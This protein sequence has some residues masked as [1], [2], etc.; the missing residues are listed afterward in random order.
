MSI[1]DQ[2]KNNTVVNKYKISI[3]CTI[4]DRPCS[5]TVPVILW[6]CLF[7]SAGLGTMFR[8]LIVV[9]N[10]AENRF[11]GV[12]LPPPATF[13]SAGYFILPRETVPAAFI[14]RSRALIRSI[15]VACSS[16]RCL[17][18][19]GLSKRPIFQCPK[20]IGQSGI[21]QSSQLP[22]ACCCLSRSSIRVFLASGVDS[23]TAY[24][25]LVVLGPFGAIH[26][27]FLLYVALSRI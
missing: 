7:C 20:R 17:I 15:G 2:N 5:Y 19:T 26:A 18:S 27:G 10:V 4:T 3:L 23:E 13:S 11:A 24:A 14:F 1:M 25:S 22:A 6:K 16:A 9:A 8:E 21:R 12:R